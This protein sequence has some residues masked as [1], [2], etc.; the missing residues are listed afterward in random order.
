MFVKQRIDLE[1]LTYLHVWAPLNTKN[2]GLLSACM[3]VYVYLLLAKLLFRT[4]NGGSTFLET[5]VN[6]YQTSRCNNRED[7]TLH[8]HSRQDLRTP[9]SNPL[10]Y[11]IWNL[12]KSQREPL[13]FLKL[14]QRNIQYVCPLVS[15]D[16]IR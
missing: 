10:G 16:D 11:R 14:P 3:H 8:N 7:G 9:G 1:I 12:I 15:Q 13:Q 2:L 5:S 6:F 4:E